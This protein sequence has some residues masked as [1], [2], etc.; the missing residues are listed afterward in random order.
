MGKPYDGDDTVETRDRVRRIE[1]RLTNLIK[2]LGFAPIPD[3][4]V[5]K[6]D[7]LVGV[8]ADGKL[9]ASSASVTLGSYGETRGPGLLALLL[10]AGNGVKA[11]GTVAGTVA[12]H[13]GHGGLAYV[14][15]K[16]ICYVCKPSDPFYGSA[17]I[18]VK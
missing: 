14:E 3:G 6:T 10:V 11:P 1:I 12:V 8:T 15:R 2:H 9:V 18:I 7:E 4:G 17:R 16:H 5:G 13:D